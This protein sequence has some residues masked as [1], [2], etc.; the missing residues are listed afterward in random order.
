RRQRADQTRPARPRP[1][2]G[3]RLRDRDRPPRRSGLTRPRPGRAPR[4]GTPP[5]RRAA[6]P[7]ITPFPPVGWDDG[8]RDRPHRAVRPA[9]ANQPPG[10]G[11]PPVAG[12]APTAV[13]PPAAH[14]IAR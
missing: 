6:P 9:G 11:V 13:R 5:R 14:T 8:A 12:A 3:A 4:T 2:G 1:G 10:R 7:R